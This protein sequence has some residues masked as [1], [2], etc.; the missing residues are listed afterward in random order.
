[1][2]GRFRTISSAT[3]TTCVGKNMKSAS[4]TNLWQIPVLLRGELELIRRWIHEWDT[5]GSMACVTAVLMGAG[6]YG[7]AMGCWRSPLQALYTAL[8][9]PL[10]ILLTTVGNAMLNA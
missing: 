8:K 2:A 4:M 7:A 3:L 9:F 6:L 5:R 10:V 1:M